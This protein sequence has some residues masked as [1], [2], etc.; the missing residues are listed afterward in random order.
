MTTQTKGEEQKPYKVLKIDEM[1]RVGE[2]G[3]V[4][5]FGRVTFKT[6]KGVTWHVDIPGENV[7]PELAAPVVEKKA[8]ELDAV[9]SL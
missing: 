1:T 4:E 7:T 3:R 5:Y 6:K 2:L 8:K 9:M